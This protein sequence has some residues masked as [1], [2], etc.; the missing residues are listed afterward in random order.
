MPPAKRRLEL[1][2]LDEL[3]A[4]VDN[5][6][7]HDLDGIRD[8]IARVGF[9]EPP[10][11]DERTGRLI[12]GH[13][14]LEALKALHS[15]EED[16][17]DGIVARK[18]RWFV[19]VMRGWSSENDAEASTY[20]LGSNR[21]SIRGGWYDGSLAAIMKDLGD[22]DPDLVRLAGWSPEQSQAV[23]DGLLGARDDGDGGDGDRGQD[24]PSDFPSYGDGIETEFRCPSCR[25]EWNGSPKP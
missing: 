15:D 13:G 20:L 3:V 12:A 10:A 8:L 14:R 16:V 21:L 7:K 24:P 25:H 4:A 11:I 18:G 5:P 9:V 22:L 17:P 2:D 23:I 6:K 19:P 1:I